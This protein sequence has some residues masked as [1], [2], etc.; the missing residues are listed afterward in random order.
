[1][2]PIRLSLAC[3][4][5][6]RTEALSTGEVMPEGIDLTYVTPSFHGSVMNHPF[7]TMFVQPEFDTAE[8]AIDDY[9]LT[10]LSRDKA[11]LTAIPVFPMR[12]F[13]HTKFAVNC[14]SGIAEPADL[15][16][17][18][19]GLT[20]YAIGAPFWARG[21][22]QHEFGVK[23]SD[24][25]WVEERRIGERVA[26][27]LGFKPPAD[28]VVKSMPE[29]SD[30]V[31]M[32]FE[33]KIDALL[34]NVGV[35]RRWLDRIEVAEAKFGKERIK[36]LFADPKAEAIRFYKKTGLFPANHVIVI[37]NEILKEYPW[38]AASLFDSFQKAK[39]LSYK[40]TA[41]LTREPTN[42]V[43]LDSLYQELN[44]TFGDDPYP[45]GVK[46]NKKLIDAVINYVYEQGYRSRKATVDELFAPATLDT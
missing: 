5:Y 32:L 33:G 11:N 13:F 19:V 15:R 28:V 1:M 20:E 29:N 40:K 9:I 36:P 39:Q 14:Q 22:L 25:E 27:V 30:L 45:Y 46:A 21:I 17:K 8:L 10:K 41:S 24:V 31:T 44:D 34:T 16:G 12:V 37:R 42:F 4:K 18:R 7:R 23:P 6:D 38:V 2:S 3:Y 35:G 43:W 26:D